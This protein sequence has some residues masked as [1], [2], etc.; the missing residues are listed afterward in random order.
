MKPIEKIWHPWEKWECYKAGFWGPYPEGVTQKSGEE[1]Y[2]D[3]FLSG[4]FR[5]TAKKVLAEWPYSCEHNL[6]STTI[7]KIAWLGQASLA[8]ATGVPAECRAGFKLLDKETQQEMNQIAR[9][10]LLNWYKEQGYE[11]PENL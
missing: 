8:Y 5:K 7:N 2:R 9:E 3:F 4:E 6:T 11:P 1:A 10:E